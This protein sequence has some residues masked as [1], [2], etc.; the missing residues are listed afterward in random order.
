MS[1]ATPLHSRAQRSLLG[2]SDIAPL[3]EAPSRHQE[4]SELCP[5]D[6]RST[7]LGE[8]AQALRDIAQIAFFWQGSC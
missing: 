3:A 7:M 5:T 4:S 8:Q 6:H 2:I 1:I